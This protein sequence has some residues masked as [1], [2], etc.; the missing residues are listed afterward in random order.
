MRRNLL[1]L[2]AMLS[3]AFCLSGRVLSPGEARTSANTFLTGRVVTGQLRAPQS[4]GLTLWRTMNDAS[5][6]AALYLFTTSSGTMIVASAESETPS[7]LG[8][9]DTPGD[10]NELNPAL[11][12]WLDGYRAEIGEYRDSEIA[13]TAATPTPK[14]I[15]HD[16]ATIQPL[17]HIK[18]NQGSPYN[19]YAPMAGTKRCPTGCVATAM[20]MVMKYHQWP[21]EHGYGTVKYTWKYD[22]TTVFEQDLEQSVYDWANMLE[23]YDDTATEA[24]NTA[25]ATLMRDVGYAVHMGYKPGGSGATTSNI[26]PA[27]RNNFGYDTATR[28]IFRYMYTLS[29]WERAIYAELAAARPV[30]LNGFTPTDAGHCF[31]CDGYGDDSFFLSIGAGAACPTVTSSCQPSHPENKVSAA[32]IRAIINPSRPLSASNRLCPAVNPSSA[33][34][35]AR[36]SPSSPALSPLP[37][38]TPSSSVLLI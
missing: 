2:A 27:L 13:T 36:I 22:G 14:R 18:W 33:W 16:L 17:M 11:Q 38:P 29:D 31:V 21:P 23:V 30:I 4:A 20:S 6:R 28:Q 10:G 32:L 35:W 24:N 8:Y 5:G 7:V 3:M 26:A 19:M 15:Q 12:E 25:V 9:T 1:L 37:P 34:V